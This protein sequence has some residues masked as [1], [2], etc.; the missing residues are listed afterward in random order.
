M[1]G[2]MN[3]K[4]LIACGD[5]FTKGHTLGEKG[6][7]AYHVAKK[8]NL[9]LINLSANGMGNEWVASQLLSFLYRHE[10]ILD[11]CIVMVGWTDFAREL[12]F[13][14]NI[15]T[16][17]V[18]QITTVPGDI[19][20][21][22]N[23]YHQ[24]PHFVEKI[25]NNRNVLK[26]FIGNEFV[27]LYKTYFSILHTQNVLEKHDVPF[28]FFDAVAN[29]KLYY[30]DT[31][32]YI[33]STSGERIHLDFNNTDIPFLQD[34]KDKTFSDKIFNNKYINFEGNSIFEWISKL[35]NQKYEEG[36]PGHTNELGASIISDMIIKEYD[37][38]Y[39]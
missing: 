13:Y 20:S 22:Q 32:P 30:N 36:N 3:K 1:F 23:D 26:N 27:C 10:S 24:A 35:E 2:K 38:L 31:I 6:S 25:I 11:E 16:S 17:R 15:E 33:L 34:F 14:I 4:Y 21:T 28:L 18:H 8:M 37:K 7:W 12:N 29:N 5:S 19:H 9:N 39:N